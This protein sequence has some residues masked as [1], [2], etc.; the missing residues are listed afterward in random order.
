MTKVNSEGSTV[1]G[2]STRG[3]SRGRKV[4]IANPISI[5][6]G[7]TPET[8]TVRPA[9]SLAPPAPSSSIPNTVIDEGSLFEDLTKYDQ[10]LTD[11]SRSFV[12]VQTAIAQLKAHRIREQ[13]T[14]DAVASTVASRRHIIAVL[15][16]R[17]EQENTRLCEAYEGSTGGKG[18]GRVQHQE[19]GEQEDDGGEFAMA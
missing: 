15:I 13:A 17:M 12:T 18:V 5:S 19:G 3:H 4:A 1:D 6:P 2:P 10:L 16:D 7:T 14:L 11:P 9:P 8:S